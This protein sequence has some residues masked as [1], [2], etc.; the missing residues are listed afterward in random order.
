M[1]ARGEIDIDLHDDLSNVNELPLLAVAGGVSR[2]RPHREPPM[3]S[4]SI[5]R[6]WRATRSSDG[7]V[8]T[9]VSNDRM[10]TSGADWLLTTRLIIDQSELNVG[11][12]GTRM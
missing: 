12:I 3:S 11:A 2:S 10:K 5:A 6:L 7:D 8:Y 1:I 4:R 9:S